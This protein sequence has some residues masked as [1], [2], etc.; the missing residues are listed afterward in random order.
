MGSFCSSVLLAAVQK[1]TEKMASTVYSNEEKTRMILALGASEMDYDRAVAKYSEMFPETRVPSSC[2]IRR[3]FVRLSETGAFGSV[4]E[5]S[6]PVTSSGSRETERVLE[7]VG[8][9]PHVGL[10]TLARRTGVSK[11]SA[12]RILHKRKYHP[13][14][15]SLHQHFQPGD[16]C[17]RLDFCN[18]ILNQTDENRN[19]LNRIIWTDEA[20]FSRNAQVNIHNAHYWSHTNPHWLRD[21]KHQY[22]WSFNV[23]AGIYNGAILGPVFSMGR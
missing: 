3:A 12:F 23:W 4:Q 11:S 13:Y 18:W 2:T 9:D 20:H 22:V 17:K 16:N 5:R 6:R 14:H 10:R 19:F 15:V 7:E 21:S 8:E 1:Q